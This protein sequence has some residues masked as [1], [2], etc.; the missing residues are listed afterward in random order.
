MNAIE[1]IQSVEDI[2]KTFPQ[3]EIQT[4]HY[5]AGGVYE[6]EIL[7]PAGTL[8]TGKI[9]LTEHL[10]KLV[11]GVLRIWSEREQGIF[12]GPLT[13]ISEPGA[14]RIGYAETD[15]V[16]STFHAVGDNTDVEA[17]E[18]ALVVDTIKQYQLVQEKAS[19]LL[20]QAEQ[21]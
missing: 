7:V 9:H 10:A 19:C 2:I 5:F 21:L 20:S 17:I 3:A 4:N 18:Q 6:R 14:K 13:F 15:V 16:F 8:I 12:T 1:A 11:S